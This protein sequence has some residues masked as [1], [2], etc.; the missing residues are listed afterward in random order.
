[1]SPAAPAANKSNEPEPDWPEV[2]IVIPTRNRAD[3]LAACTRGLKEKTDYPAFNVVIVD[4]GSRQARARALL[5]NL[6]ADARYRILD[7]PEPFNYAKLSNDGA[8]A[9][10]SPMLVFLNN[11]IQMIDARNLR[12]A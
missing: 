4:N 10:N 9:T 1:M 5:D 6:R 2:S 3:L 11:D 8:R 12:H 7:R